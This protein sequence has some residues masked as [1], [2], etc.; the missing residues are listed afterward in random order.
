MQLTRVSKHVHPAVGPRGQVVLI[1]IAQPSNHHRGIATGS[2]RCLRVGGQTG[3]GDGLRGVELETCIQLGEGGLHGEL[4]S[5]VIQRADNVAALENVV[6][7]L[8]E[9]LHA[10]RAEN[11]HVTNFA[12]QLITHAQQ[13]GALIH[14]GALETLILDTQ[15]TAEGPLAAVGGGV[16]DHGTGQI[17]ALSTNDHPPLAVAFK[18]VR[19]TVVRGVAL[20]RTGNQRG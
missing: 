3:A 20:L 14:I 9:R 16:H 7:L 1:S 13:G 6:V 15:L 5:L 11:Q 12:G 4:E 8:A 10:L 19:V 2:M 17:L 18:D